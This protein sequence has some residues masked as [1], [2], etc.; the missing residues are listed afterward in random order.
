MGKILEMDIRK[1]LGEMG[2]LDVRTQVRPIFSG[3]DLGSGDVFD[4]VRC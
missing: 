1:R 2:V 4:Q 3:G